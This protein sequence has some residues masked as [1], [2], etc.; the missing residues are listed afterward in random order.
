MAKQI[1]SYNIAASG[2]MRVEFTDGTSQEMTVEQLKALQ[3]QSGG[4]RAGMDTSDPED[5]P[6]RPNSSGR[7]EDI[8][9]PLN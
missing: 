3:Q 7:I 5:A 8:G 6:R 2:K 4:R 9:T 1:K